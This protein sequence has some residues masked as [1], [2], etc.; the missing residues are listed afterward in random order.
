MDYSPKGHQELEMTETMTEVTYHTPM[1]KVACQAPLCMGLS[2][3]EDWSG[4]PCP[5]P[6]DLPNPGMKHM[7]PALLA[8]T[9]GFFI[10]EPSRKHP[11]FKH[12]CTE[13]Q[14]TQPF[15]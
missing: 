11:G 5:P 14:S 7:S 2:W 13:L 6:R 8:L 1:Q 15:S 3:Q 4:L 9:D 12:S 10:T